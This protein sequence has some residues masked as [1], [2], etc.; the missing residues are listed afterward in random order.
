MGA[1]GATLSA[2]KSALSGKGSRG[3]PSRERETWILVSLVVRFM[4]AVRRGGGGLDIIIVGG[5]SV[6][7]GFI[8]FFSRVE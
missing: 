8:F 6:C 7:A 1:L 5:K 3:P 2:V 4:R